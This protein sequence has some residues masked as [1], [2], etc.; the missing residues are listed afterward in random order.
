[1]AHTPGGR[2][3]EETD[4]VKLAA[5]LVKIPSITGQEGDAA[6]YIA[7]AMKDIGMSVTFDEAAPGRRNVIGTLQGNPRSPVLILNGHI[8]VVPPGDPS[9]WSVDPFGGVIRDE[10]L[11]GRGSADMKGGLAALLTAIRIFIRSGDKMKGTIILEAVIDEENGGRAGT[12]RLTIDTPI[13]GDFACI[14]EPTNLELQTAHKG[15]LG[16]EITVEGRAAHAATPERGSNAVHKMIS[17]AGSLLEIPRRY[18]WEGRLHPLLGPPYITI[19]VIEGG[20]QRNI[21]PD[22]CRII[23]D[24]R[25]LPRLESLETAKAEIE[26]TLQ[27]ARQRDPELRATSRP[28]LEIESMETDHDQLIVRRF[29]EAYSEATGRPPRIA[30]L[31]G[32][33]D[34][35]YYQRNLGIPV[36]IF[37]PGRL[38]EAHSADEYVETTQLTQ[39]TRVYTRLLNNLLT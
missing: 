18:A 28:I 12:G 2:T 30:G 26:E 38:E 6:S 25:T 5:D 24:R 3:G 8:D 27:Q 9:R 11:Y 37:G 35:H 16:M 34:A 39:A 15:D 10:R 1:M 21:I 14:A 20:L 22:R 19:S 36:I 17:L 29:T 7:S 4:A 13:R 23:V 33:C 31:R 32:F